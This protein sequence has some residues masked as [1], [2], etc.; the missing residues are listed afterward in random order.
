MAQWE[1]NYNKRRSRRRTLLP[2]EARELKTLP[3]IL[4]GDKD[5]ID[6]KKHFLDCWS[7]Q[8]H[9]ARY[10]IG[11]AE[12]ICMLGSRF[13]AVPSVAGAE[14][15]PI[16]AYCGFAPTGPFRVIN[17]LSRTRRI[18]YSDF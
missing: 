6:I 5:G 11:S 15:R 10:D 2:S 13:G 7:I 9:P 8:K 17:K 14:M 16:V 12:S 3:P 4:R 18:N 1:R